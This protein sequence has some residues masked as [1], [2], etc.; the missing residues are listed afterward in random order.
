MRKDSY[1]ATDED[2][3]EVAECKA[4]SYGGYIALS[5]L[6]RTYHGRRQRSDL[7]E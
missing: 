4:A 7:A 1:R 5:Y 3:E 6:G 2:M